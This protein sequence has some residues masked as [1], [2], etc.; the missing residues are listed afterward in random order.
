MDRKC[1][2]CAAFEESFPIGMGL[3]RR[4]A[5]RPIALGLLP[6]DDE[7]QV[8]PHA[9]VAAFLE[10]SADDWCLEFVPRESPQAG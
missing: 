1:E 9:D 3:C 4:Y 2:N 6:H 5:P 10:V 7:W 8:M